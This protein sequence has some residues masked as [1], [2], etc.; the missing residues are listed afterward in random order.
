MSCDLRPFTGAFRRLCLKFADA[1]CLGVH[2]VSEC[3]HLVLQ[4]SKLG[5][6]LIAVDHAGGSSRERLLL[7]TAR[8]CGHEKACL[9]P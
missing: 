2:Q 1:V 8:P 3:T 6:Q 7:L 5:H 4:R 9:D